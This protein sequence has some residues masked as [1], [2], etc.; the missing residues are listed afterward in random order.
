MLNS[1]FGFDDH[2][3]TLNKALQLGAVDFVAAKHRCL[4]HAEGRPLEL[5]LYVY[6]YSLMPGHR[7]RKIKRR[8]AVLPGPT[9]NSSMSFEP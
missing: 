5:G 2:W 8:R 1:S 7:A 9:K 6:P 4:C 3:P